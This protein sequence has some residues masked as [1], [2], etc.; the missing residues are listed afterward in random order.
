MQPFQQQGE[1]LFVAVEFD[2]VVDRGQQARGGEKIEQLPAQWRPV[3][4]FV[5]QRRAAV[6][7]QF[8]LG[9][10][11]AAAAPFAQKSQRLLVRGQ[12]QR[13]LAAAAADGGQQAVALVAD[14]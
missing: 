2:G 3:F 7:G 1:R 5:K 8:G 4:R 12:R 11:F 14:Q 6:K 13:Q 9:R 10:V